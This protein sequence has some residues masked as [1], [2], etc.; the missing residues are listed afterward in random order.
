MKAVIPALLEKEIMAE[1]QRNGHSPRSILGEALR[2]GLLELANAR[3]GGLNGKGDYVLKHPEISCEIMVGKLGCPYWMIRQHRMNYLAKLLRNGGLEKPDSELSRLTGIPVADVSCKR[4][5]LGYK[6]KRACFV[7]PNKKADC[8]KLWSRERLIKALTVDGFTSVDILKEIYGKAITRQRFQQ[9]LFAKRDLKPE[10]LK[11]ERVWFANRFLGKGKEKDAASISTKRGFEAC[12]RKEGSMRALA[13][14][15]NASV[16]SLSNF[17]RKNY[18]IGM[19]GK[20][21]SCEQER[22]K[23]ICPQCKK[24]FYRPKAEVK[25]VRRQK[26][27]SKFICSNRCKWEYAKGKKLPRHK[28]TR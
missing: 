27:G 7:R 6:H 12:F 24:P 14:K 21:V 5:A 15:F 3:A 20:S 18:G 2:I 19:N 22:V 8:S 23:L 13:G 17:A 28:K 1:S 9:L 16:I 4:R 11:V 26:P 10:D 25:M